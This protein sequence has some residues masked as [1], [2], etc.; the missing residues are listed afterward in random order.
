MIYTNVKKEF[1]LASQTQAPRQLQ[2][3][4]KAVSRRRW[5]FLLKEIS[6]VSNT[7]TNVVVLVRSLPGDSFSPF[8]LCFSDES[9]GLSHHRSVSVHCDSARRT[10]LWMSQDMSHCRLYPILSTAKGA[11]LSTAKL[12]LSVSG[13]TRVR[14]TTVVCSFQVIRHQIYKLHESIEFH[15]HLFILSTAQSEAPFSGVDPLQRLYGSSQAN[16]IRRPLLRHRG[17][18]QIWIRRVSFHSNSE[19]F[20]FFT[21]LLSCGAVCTGPEDAI[22]I[23]HVFLV[24]ES[25]L[26]TS[27]VTIS[28]LP[29]FVV[30]AISTQSSFVLISLSSSLEELSILTYLLELCFVSISPSFSSEKCPLSPSLLSMKRDVF[31]FHYQVS[32]SVSSPLALNVTCDYFSAARLCRESYI[33]AVKLCPDFAVI[34]S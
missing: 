9:R 7:K 30:K 23:T 12:P 15:R 20:S 22:E 11:Q 31:L 10:H 14:H 8:G 25:W 5:T 27:L 3:P 26:S 29:D 19:D 2:N 4:D 17:T 13:K 28:Q 24:G 33:D 32:V 21:G 6:S 34:F 16:F 1:A 18:V